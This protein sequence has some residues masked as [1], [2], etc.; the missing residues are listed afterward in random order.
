M[1]RVQDFVADLL[2]AGTS[3]K[4]AKKK[5]IADTVATRTEQMVLMFPRGAT[6]NV[7]YIVEALRR[8]LKA[9]RKKRPHLVTEE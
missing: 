2:R 6:V 3:I 5:K 1:A 4:E 9:L 8:F 7:A